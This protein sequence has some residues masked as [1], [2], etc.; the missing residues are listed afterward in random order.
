MPEHCYHETGAV[1]SSLRST[2]HE[3]ICC[4]CGALRSLTKWYEDK[5]LEGHGPF[6]RERVMTAHE[7]YYYGILK[8]GVLPLPPEK[9]RGPGA[10]PGRE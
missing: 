4:Y 2:S 1:S 10:C 3:Q 6:Y 7:Y 9:G 8:R 5:S